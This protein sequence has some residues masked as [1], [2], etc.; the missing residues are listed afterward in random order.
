MAVCGG[1]V[2]GF[3]EE[4]LVRDSERITLEPEGGGLQW[5]VMSRID[6]V[7]HGPF[8]IGSEDHDEHL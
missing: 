3:A 2:L 8:A 4:P 7:N 1:A 5:R 6:L